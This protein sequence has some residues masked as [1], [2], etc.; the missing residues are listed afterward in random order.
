MNQGSVAGAGIAD[1]LHQ[2]VVPR[3]GGDTNFMPV[4]GLTRV[5]PQV[6]AD[7]RALLAA[8]WPAPRRPG[9]RAPGRV[10]P[11]CSASTSARR[12]AGS[13]PPSSAAWLRAGVTADAVTLTGTLGAVAARGLPDRHRPPLLG[14]VRRHRLRAAGHARRRAGPRPGRRLGVRRGAGL[15]RRPGRRRRHLRRRWPGGSPGTGDNRLIVALA[16]VCLVLGVLTSY[17]KAR[18]EGMGLRVEVGVVER[19]ERLILVLVGTGLRRPGHPLRAARLPVGAARRQRDH[20]RP[21]VRR[22]PQ[23]SR[24]MSL[25]VAAA[26]AP[27][28]RAVGRRAGRPADAV[29]RRAELVH[30]LTDAGYAAGW[31]AVRLLPEPVAGGLFSAGGALAARRAG[32]GVRQL[33]ANLDVVTGGR[34][35]DA[36]LDALTRRGVQSYARYW[37]EAFRLPTLSRERVVAHY[38]MPGREHLE[39]AVAAGRGVVLAL[40][41][42]G[43]WDAAGV[44]LVDFLGGEFLTVVERLR[45]GVAV[46]PVRRATGEGLGM[47]VVPLT[48]GERPSS[49]VLRE[50][51]T[52]GGIDVPAGRPGPVRLRGAGRPSSAA[53]R[54]CPAGRRCWPPRPGRR[55]CR[56][57]ASSTARAGGSS[58]TRRCRSTGPGG[59]ATASPRRCSRSPTRSPPRSPSSPRT[60]TCW[61]GSGRGGP[62]PVRRAARAAVLETEGLG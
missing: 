55:C 6:L 53:G 16:L 52:A 31:R 18:A 37:Q 30:R 23:R 59:C 49:A 35:D 4:V 54:R 3:W 42:S 5:L 2:H 7:T 25:P 60:G 14:R 39:Q 62:R 50:W 24:G 8:Q 36:A 34:L 40:P 38:R 27:G 13:G 44:W 28:H 22:R 19:T 51:L 29:S 21:A 56:P 41:H 20:G 57:S 11:E 17:V 45:A 1:H 48:G 58:S 43:N 26:G 15:H 10:W 32:R 46:P 61:A 12:S 33:R 9:P 47:R